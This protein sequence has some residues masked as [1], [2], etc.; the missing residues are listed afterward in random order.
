VQWLFEQRV[1]TA[2]RSEATEF[3]LG[4]LVV[5]GLF[6]EA[7]GV[8]EGARLTLA[9]LRAAGFA[10]VA[11]DLRPLFNTGGGFPA[12]DPGGVWLLHVNAP[13]AIQALGR[14]DPASWLGRYRI[15]YWAYE[16]PRVPASWVR[17]AQAFHEIW[18]PSRFVVD[19]LHASGV[20]TPVKLMPHPVA[21][22]D[23]PEPPDRAAFGLPADAFAVLAMGDLHSSATRKNLVGAIDAYIRAFRSESDARLVVKVREEGAHPAF[24]ALARQHAR[25]RDDISFMTSDLSSRDMRRLIASCDVV[26]SPHRSEGF[27]LPLA[28]AFLAGVPAVATGWSGNLE[29]MSD[30]T[31]LHIASHPAP[32]NDAYRIYRAAGLSWAE[33]DPEDAATKLR[34]L[35]ASPDLRRRLAERG[36]TAV[37]ALSLPWRRDALLETPLGR[38]VA[39][40]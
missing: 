18:A 1:R 7:K 34:A 32:V 33:P 24:L 37:K 35:A 3:V 5:S 16:L 25:G 23:Q 12:P 10:P 20:T 40:P 29:F 36:R 22:G 8:S 21:L 6:S 9:G 38:L 14:I 31:E 28:E 4:P 39:K 13:E 30:L 27:G 11:H 17:I 26:L 15:G 2:L 19:A